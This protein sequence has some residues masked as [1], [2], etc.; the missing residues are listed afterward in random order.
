M[1]NIVKYGVLLMACVLTLSSCNCFKK[2]AKNQDQ[3]SV[4]AN[5]EVLTLV[6]NEIVTDVTVVF[7]AKYYNPKAIVKVTP[8]LVFD[9]GAIEGAPKFFQG[10]K[11]KDNYTV[12]SKTSG[13]VFTQR[14]AFPWDPRAR[15]CVLELKVEGKC[16]PD[17]DFVLGGVIPVAEGVNT[18]QQDLSYSDAM[19]VMPDDFKRVTHETGSVDI[20][21]QVNR[22]NVRT[23][24]LSKEQTKLFED[25]IRENQNRDR[26][27]LGN[28]Q[29]RGYASPEGP[30]GFNDKLSVARSQSGKTAIEKQLKNTN[31][32]Y[33]VASFGE[34]WEGFKKLV[35]ESNM[36]DK[37]MIIQV[38]NMYS[39]AA[40]RDVEIRNMSA[41]FEELKQNILPE[42]RRTQVLATTDIQ[43]KT[44]AELIAAAGSNVGSLNLEETLFAA[45]LF[46]GDADKARIYKSA[47]DRFNDPR[48][49]NNLGIALAAQNDWTGAENAFKKA[50]AISSNPAM[51]NNLAL[52]A[53]AQGNTAEAAK[54]LP[55]A[56]AGAKALDQV[57]KGNYAAAS[58]GLEGYNK[59]VADVLGGNLSAAK[60]ALVGD[61]SAEADYLRGVIAAKE[62]DAAAAAASVKAAIAK[63]PALRA[64]ALADINL[65]SIAGQL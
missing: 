27:T 23:T 15:K 43:G 38:L 17:A 4:S 44:D 36:R 18:L 24:E 20:M 10:E 33:D 62:G 37:S 42:L 13:G 50:T 48:A 53:M 5:P 52:T 39:S 16:K 26:V 31:L 12:I 7:P 57:Y 51:A 19:I 35:E 1:K 21:Y 34:D 8:I 22:S 56:S 25:F 9:G 45:T 59:A 6:G 41:V 46:S 49:W 40:Q 32:K 14:I 65:K 55:T 30:E 47:A 63:E 60:N 29:A 61:T 54:Y 3:I 58:T 28:I 64:K 11:V 2:M